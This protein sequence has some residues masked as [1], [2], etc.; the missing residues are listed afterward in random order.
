M[1][2][3]ILDKDPIKAAAYHFNSHVVKIPTEVAQLLSFVLWILEPEKAYLWYEKR[4]IY[5]VSKSYSKHPCTLWIMESRANYRWAC[6]YGLALC[7][8]Y[9][10][11]YGVDKNHHHKAEDVIWFAFTQIPSSLPPYSLTP[12]K[13]AI[14]IEF[15]SSN[16]IESYRMYYRSSQKAHLRKWGKRR[17]IPEWFYK[18]DSN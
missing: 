3:F 4:L 9:W 18:V 6:V 5:K 14:P 7:A 13:Q 15:Q 1:Q 16:A 10:R 8:E 17:E 11:R 12:F 2:L